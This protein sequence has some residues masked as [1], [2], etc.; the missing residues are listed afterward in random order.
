[1][2]SAEPTS[3]RTDLPHREPSTESS[4]DSRW[5]Y[6]IAAYPIFS[7]LAV[8][9]ALLVLVLF[10]P[11]G[12]VTMGQDPQFVGPVVVA[13]VALAVGAATVYA[14]V[15][16]VLTVMLPV[17]LYLDAAELAESAAEWSP[18]PILYGLVGL[19]NFLA[20]PFVGLVVAVYY[21]YRRHQFVG[22]P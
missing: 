15:G 5:W 1:M 16:L 21:L 3:S 13:V 14:L 4:D 20:A 22:V 2:D 7:L 18:D 6:W 17:A 12:F 11:L 10:A 9:L 8:P 19:L